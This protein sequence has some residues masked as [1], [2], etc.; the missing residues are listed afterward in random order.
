MFGYLLL[1]LL[2]IGAVGGLVFGLDDDDDNGGTTPG[3]PGENDEGDTLDGTDGSDLLQGAA[4]D[5]TIDG[6]A[7][8]DRLIGLG[9]GDQVS[10]GAGD[11][12]VSGD[13]GAD[14]LA[15][16][17][18]D[19]GVY[20][21]SGGDI[22]L[23]GDG[24]D[25]IWGGSNGDLLVGG[26]GQDTMNGS[27]GDDVLIG[28]QTDLEDG[29]VDDFIAG[30]AESGIT[31][32]EQAILTSLA[33]SGTGAD[34]EAGDEM[35]GGFGDD[36]LLVGSED[37]ASGGDG[38]DFFLMGDWIQAGRAAEIAD[39]DPESDQIA[40]GFNT[41]EAPELT[42]TDDGEGNAL[43]SAG[44]QLLATVTGAAETLSAE[45]IAVLAYEDDITAGLA[46]TGTEN[47]D[48]LRGSLNDDVVTG[49]GGDDTISLLA[50]DDIVRGNAGG[51]LIEAGEGNDRAFGQ[52]GS[53][54][55]TGGMGDDLLRGGAEGDS[56]T[57]AQGADTLLGD[58]GD[59]MIIG[60]SFARPEG[61]DADSIGDELF[62]GLGDDQI[63]FGDNDTVGGGFGADTLTTSSATSGSVITDFEV[64]SDVLVV[65]TAAGA[66]PT[67]AVTYSDGASETEGDATVTL[68]GNPFMVVQG[69]GT[70]FTSSAIT[71]QS[72]APETPVV[73]E[74]PV[75]PEAPV[76]P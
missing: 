7:G 59:D 27:S 65:N 51:D 56:L 28:T 43:V 9:G 40:F 57:D 71:V 42:V 33:L 14:I 48:D 22:A 74:A 24:D 13:D 26:E 17:A 5:D 70:S 23:G 10:G 39:Y 41:E 69:V 50:G 1:A 37:T 44:D 29:S 12:H 72:A 63:T 73:P 52:D 25:D 55:L 58:A 30:L 45:D 2:G 60:S 15:G 68:D 54:T 61:P 34:G 46:I 4:E 20:G 66:T 35:N 18:G 75:T 31:D 16:G 49:Q 76:S 67:I 6:G 32:P 19:D 53:D 47:A 11:D 38:N 3:T 62:G 64:D 36:V 21:G 8:D